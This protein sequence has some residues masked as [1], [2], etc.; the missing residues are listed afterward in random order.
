[1]LRPGVVRSGLM[2]LGALAAFA[3]VPRAAHAA[4]CHVDDRPTLGGFDYLAPYLSADAVDGLSP[5]ERF[6]WRPLPCSGDTSTAAPTASLTPL[7][8]DDSDFEVAAVIA[9]AWL[10][11]EHVPGS[12]REGSAPPDPPPRFC[13]GR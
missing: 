6:N 4:G 13:A 10:V 11:A 5:F 7:A 2:A 3:V 9:T 8:T 12:T 1:M